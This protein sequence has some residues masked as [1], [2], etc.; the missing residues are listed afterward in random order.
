MNK[1]EYREEVLEQLRK[2]ELNTEVTGLFSILVNALLFV[3][4]II[5]LFK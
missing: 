5:V 3:L 2:I 1:D 4:A